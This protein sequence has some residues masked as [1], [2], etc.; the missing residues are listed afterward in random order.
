MNHLQHKFRPLSNHSPYSSNSY[1]TVHRQRAMTRKALAER[2]AENEP[3]RI[4]PRLLWSARRAAILYG[5]CV[6]GKSHE[7]DT[8]ENTSRTS[9]ARKSNIYDPDAAK[10]F[11]AP[12]GE[13]N[14]WWVEKFEARRRAEAEAPAAAK[15]APQAGADESL[16]AAHLVGPTAATDGMASSPGPEPRTDAGATEPGQGSG[17]KTTGP[18]RPTTMSRVSAVLQVVQLML[19]LAALILLPASLM[20]GGLLVGRVW[21]LY[22]GYL[23]FFVQGTLYRLLTFGPLA[24][25]AQDKQRTSSHPFHPARIA[26]VY[27]IMYVPLLHWLTLQRYLSGPLSY[28]TTLYDVLGALLIGGGIVLNYAASRALGEAYDQVVA[29]D[30]LVTHG[31]YRH[32]QHPIYTS[33]LMLF[34]GYCLALHSAPYALITLLLCGSYYRLRCHLESLVLTEAFGEQYSAYAKRTKM[35]VPLL[36]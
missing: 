12:P 36:V 28:E 10:G 11:M 8:S 2:T 16:E 17:S 14:L 26:L 23:V 29:P 34:C 18:A 33:Y 4:K 27:L 15:A 35:F 20:P 21:L 31:P 3:P 24:S 19:V 6:H 22:V 9:D 1:V 25:R 13:R 5:L 32:V 30:S 7:G